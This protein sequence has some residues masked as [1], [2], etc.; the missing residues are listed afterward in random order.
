MKAIAFKTSLLT[1]LII[2]FVGAFAFSVPSIGST[3]LDLD[4]GLVGYWNFDEGSGTIAHDQ[5]GNGHNGTI[6]GATWTTDGVSGSAIYVAGNSPSAGYVTV[7]NV[8]SYAY[9]YNI[10]VKPDSTITEN[11]G[12]SGT[13]NSLHLTT[14]STADNFGLG[15]CTDWLTNETITL[16]HGESGNQRRTGVID[17]HISNTAWHMLTF[18]WNS[19]QSRYDIYFDGELKTV[20][21][22]TFGHVQLMPCSY[23]EINRNYSRYVGK[24]DEVRIY[25][26]ALSEAEI[27]ELYNMHAPYYFIHLSDTHIGAAGSTD[28]FWAVLNDIRTNFDNPEPA[29][30][31]ISGDV[32]N[33]GM[34][35]CYNAFKSYLY[36]SGGQLYLDSDYDVPVYVCPGNHD[37]YP[38]GLGIID[39]TAAFGLPQFYDKTYANT[40]IVSF[41]SGADWFGIYCNII[42][43]ES[44]QLGLGQSI[45][46]D[47]ILA[48]YP[49]YHKIIFLH[50]PV[51]FWSSES[52]CWHDGCLINWPPFQ[53]LC[54][55]HAVDLVLSGHI[56]WSYLYTASCY[57]NRTSGLTN[58][59]GY[60]SGPHHGWVNKPYYASD[61]YNETMY[62]G[63][64]SAWQSQAYRVIAVEGDK[65]KVYEPSYA[66]NSAVVSQRGAAGGPKNS[67]YKVASLHV[68]DSQGHHTGEDGHGGVEHQIS[69]AGFD[70]DFVYVDSISG[71]HDTIGSSGFVTYG[72]DDY[73]F[74]VQG[75]NEGL[76]DLEMMCTFT[77]GRN[78]LAWFNDVSV[79][80][81]SIGRIYVPSETIDLILYMDDDGD[82]IVDREIQPDTVIGMLR[83]DANGDGVINVT[84][85]VYLINYLFLVPP[86]PAP[87]PL[88]SGDA[89]CDG[90]IN[91]TDVVYLINYLFLVPPGPPPCR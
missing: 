60:D 39:Y 43:P 64:G 58:P 72:L 49:D 77:S 18:V 34:L 75:S 85:V 90:I 56:H 79:T 47:D 71:E 84:D 19:G 51:F 50:H 10:W 1:G 16:V 78:I 14:F 28:A 6:Y 12:G 11:T 61:D 35:V 7:G 86:G 76:L 68:Y 74:E 45:W 87:Q 37:Y 21:A 9:T 13:G 54:Y 53:A 33:I 57:P 32:A 15:N 66:S 73:I 27:K 4:S 2:L 30:V 89:N 82:G 40:H 41:S 55:L 22:S 31:V 63:V 69:G 81:S 29:F 3:N 65:I 62:A 91:V 59:S 52:K 20:V 36:E 23:F 80:D 83:G 5:S 17:Q 67:G 44:D 46:L 26:R 70:Y 25:D 38:L 8:G 88:A 42:P 24:I 48:Q